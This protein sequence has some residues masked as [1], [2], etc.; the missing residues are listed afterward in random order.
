MNQAN[1]TLET[2]QSGAFDHADNTPTVALLERLFVLIKTVGTLGTTHPQALEGAGA[3][4]D[5]VANAKPPFSLQF[6]REATFRDR[7]LLPLDLE[8]F[9]RSQVLS[10]AMSH[11]G[12][13]ELSFEAIPGPAELLKFAQVLARGAQGPTDWL[14][15]LALNGLSWRE[16]AGAGWGAESQ[17]ID[18]DLFAVTQL[19]LA[20]AEA[21]RL[22]ADRN[23]PWH[24]TAGVGVVR[25]L[26]R[27]LEVDSAAADRALELAPAPWSPG[28]RAVAVTMRVVAV[29]REMGSLAGTTRAAGHAALVLGVFGMATNNALTMQ[30]AAATG[31]PRLLATTLESAGGAA[32]HRIRVCALLNA[33]H[34]RTAFHG[35]WVGA[36]GLIDVL[37]EL[38]RRRQNDKQSVQ[39]SLADLLAGALAE[40]QSQLD[41]A[42]LRALVATVGELP[43]G[44]RVRLA[45][46]RVGVVLEPGPSG[47]PWRP[48]VLVQGQMV[49]P[50]QPVRLQAAVGRAR[51]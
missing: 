11:C 32:R 1:Q 14:E 24:W 3:M 44:A 41:P 35:R 46:G 22:V 21:E 38:E 26:E 8:G 25:R 49:E 33:V 36:I 15:S 29:L 37:Y 51:A 39:L 19:A 48:M 23:E 6:V 9:Q 7:T 12:V 16:I 4:R 31:L 28:R 17:A 34:R 45:D 5:A 13:Q 20:I 50:Q 42:W 2:A 47:D 18:A 10:R 30:D 27:A 40:A 43:P